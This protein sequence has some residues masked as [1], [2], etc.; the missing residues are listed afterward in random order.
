V[1]VIFAGQVSL[2]AVPANVAAAPAV[3]VATVAGLAAL[4][5]GPAWPAGAGAAAAVGDLATGWI[6]WV[7]RGLASWPL[8]A[9]SW[10]TGAWG[11]V[12]ATAATAALAAS[13]WA[14]RRAPPR[15]RRLVGATAAAASLAAVALAG[16]LRAPLLTVMGAGPPEDWLAAVCDVGQGTAVAAR[17]GPAAAV[18]I[19]VGPAEGDVD[20]CLDQLGVTRLDAV[21]L[22]HFHSDHV[23]GLED[24]AEGRDWVELVHGPACGEQA[25][26]DRAARLA[27]GAGA[28]RRQVGPEAAPFGGAVGEA[29]VTV[30]PSPLAARCPS[31]TSGAEESAANDASLAVLVEADG[32][33]LWVLGDLEAAGQD[34]LLAT[35]RAEAATSADGQA[36]GAGGVVVVA[37]HGSATQ[38][39]ALARALSPRLAVMSAGRSNP[40]GHPTDA[41]IDLYARFGQVRRT[42]QEGLVAISAADLASQR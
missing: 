27:D 5:L 31:Q 32:I 14:L 18:L 21:I 39:A 8:A 29:Q 6:A 16:P 30:Y 38:S 22:T 9:I 33:A 23:G 19:D 4:A 35:L 12:S 3:P 24:A 37:H 7:A 25:A 42:D 28:R 34:A 17:T 2:T 10:P 26:A 36:R 11:F 1:I 20:G 15:V 40:Y 41:A 13:V